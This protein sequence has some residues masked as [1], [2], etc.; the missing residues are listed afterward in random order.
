MS[1]NALPLFPLIPIPSPQIPTQADPHSNADADADSVPK[2]TKQCPRA[3]CLTYCNL[4]AD[5]LTELRSVKNLNSA[6][7]ESTSN[8]AD[9]TSCQ[10]SGFYVFHEKV[11]L[12][13]L[14]TG[15]IDVGG[16]S[17]GLQ[18]Q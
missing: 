7:V 1:D 15:P 11:Q 17:S 9:I 12:K 2:A 5:L 13:E 18:M 8:N 4:V 10:P 3:A 14:D 16:I 6:M